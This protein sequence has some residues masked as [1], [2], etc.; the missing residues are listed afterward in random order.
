MNNPSGSSSSS[1]KAGHR[2]A[3]FLVVALLH[4]GLILGPLWMVDL[5]EKRKPEKN[6]F[7]VKIGGA[8]LSS[9]PVVGM[10]ERTPPR[11]PAPPAPP[12]PEIVPLPQKKIPAE[13][14][15]PV[16]KPKPKVKP[17]PEPKV[18][19]KKKIVKP[20]PKVKPRPEPKVPVKKNVVK[21]KPKVKPRPEPKVPVK[22]KIVK[23]KPKVKPRPVR[24]NPL[25]DVYKDPAPVNLP[26]RVPVGRNNRAQQYAP[27]A[28]NKA[29]GGGRTVDEAAW[30]RY[31]KNVERYIY[32]RWTEPPRSLLGDQY[33]ETV[34]E[35]TVEASGKVSSARIVR[36]SGNRSME[37][38]VEHLLSGLDLLPRPPEGRITFRITLKAR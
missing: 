37:S 24:R 2:A 13:P 5:F 23:P 7:R 1:C 11:P 12:E 27:K 25:D 20:K 19:V 18:P 33:P 4:A 38:S 9:G 30:A 32:S 36:A 22:K 29:P 3:T 15:I 21:P 17:R 28:D 26:P 16:V 34:I 8:E 6:M 31:G 10:P 35:V 14:R